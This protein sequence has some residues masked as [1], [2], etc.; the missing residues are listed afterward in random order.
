VAPAFDAAAVAGA[1]EGVEA[2]S[3]YWKPYFFL[4]ESRGL[5]CRLV[6]ARD[7]KNLAEVHRDGIVAL[8]GGRYQVGFTLAG[9]TI[10]LRLD[11][12]AQTKLSTVTADIFGV[13]GRAML[14]ALIAGERNPK[15]LAELAHGTIKAGHA[16]GKTSSTA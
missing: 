10:T 2:T 3:T 12:D 9:R 13:S 5:E 16:T 6:D 15:A 7:V 4:L 11:G 14:E 8:A 1:E